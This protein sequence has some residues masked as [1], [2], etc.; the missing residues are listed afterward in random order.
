VAIS[1]KWKKEQARIARAELKKVRENL[2]SI[3]H[4][5][6][7]ISIM[8][9][10]WV[11]QNFKTEGGKVGGWKPFKAGGRWITKKGKRQLDTSAKLLQDTGRL[12]ASFKPFSTA[13]MAGIGSALEYS[14]T[15]EKG[16]G[17]PARRMLPE[18]VDVDK[19]VQRLMEHHLTK[20]IKK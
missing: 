20:G 1:I 19:Q 18:K 7:K 12:R 8:L 17:V 6:A 14:E 5:M 2:N 3:D 13:N 15:H 9:D 4:V 10:R 11:Q 16:L